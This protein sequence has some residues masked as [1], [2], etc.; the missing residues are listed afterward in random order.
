MSRRRETIGPALSGPIRWDVVPKPGG[1]VR[2]LLVLRRADELA[3]ARSVAGATPAICRAMGS[4]SHANRLVAWDPTCGLVLEPWTRAR[5]RWER[6]VGRLEG[7]ARSIA[8]TDARACYASISARVIVDRLADLGV[9]DAF[10]DQIGSWL[11]VLR[12]MGADGL[13]VGP[14]PSAVLADAVLSAGDDAIRATGA[15][16]VRWVDDVMIFAPDAR[17]RAIAL[18]AL[19]RAWAPFGLEIHD[20]K[21]V[22]LDGVRPG[23]PD[24]SPLGLAVASSALR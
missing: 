20:G 10:V 7:R 11:H 24:R 1:G 22:L 19:R 21:T 9:P 15:D 2:R 18:D 12:D 16:H 4:E 17:T 3:F 23:R 14:A 13:P 6:D 8:A 5:R